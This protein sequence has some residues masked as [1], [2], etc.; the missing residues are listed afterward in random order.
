MARAW[1]A[2][3]P[4]EAWWRN[5]LSDAAAEIMHRTRLSG[6]AA[7]VRRIRAKFNGFF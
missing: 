2:A 1:A 7:V 4:A 3:P 5:R 6:R